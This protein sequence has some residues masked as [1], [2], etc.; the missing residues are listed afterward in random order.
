VA[1]SGCCNAGRI[2][3]RGVANKSRSSC[4]SFVVIDIDSIVIVWQKRQNG[5]SKSVH[6]VEK[7]LN[8]LGRKNNEGLATITILS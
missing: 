4:Y 7:F 1:G 8:N 5:C 3:R 2:G 6:I